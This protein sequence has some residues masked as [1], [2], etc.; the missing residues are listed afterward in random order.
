MKKTSFSLRTLPPLALPLTIAVTTALLALG[1]L[2]S[3]SSQA[4]DG[5]APV[6]ASASASAS[7]KPALTVTTAQPSRS[8]LPMRLSANGNIAAWQ[9]ASI[10]SESGGLRLQEVRA[11]VGDPVQRDQILA[12]FSAESVLAD[13]ASAKAAVAEA[14]AN[15][16]EASANAERARALLNSGA[17]SAQQIAQYNTAQATSQAHLE[18]ALAAQSQQD[19]RL[20]HTL[21][22][23]PDS[24]VISARSATVGAVLGVG[25]ELFRLIRQGRLEWR[26]EV[27]SAELPLIHS[28]TLVQINSAAGAQVQGKVR[29]VAPTVDPQTRAALVYVDFS[30]NPRNAG[31]KPG[32]FA[33]G[34]FLLGSSDALTVPQQAVVARDGFQYVFKVGPNQRIAQQKVSVGRRVGEQVEILQGLQVQDTVAVVG[35]GFLNDG[36]TV[37]IGK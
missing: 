1:L 20:E 26:A 14:R 25:T 7:A 30:G 18:S 23:A 32:M 6:S 33:H 8:K 21:V 27:T 4:Q 31:L 22:R 36:D 28:G 9:E 24:G 16:S 2:S 15:A 3:R 34:D 17:L 10:G 12:V 29:M 5:K 37:R 19:L 13:V 35:A 11:N